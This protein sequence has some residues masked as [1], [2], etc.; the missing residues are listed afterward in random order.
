MMNPNR[1]IHEIGIGRMEEGG[2]VDS[3]GCAFEIL[4]KNP[5]KGRVE[6]KRLLKIGK[7]LKALASEISFSE[8]FGAVASVRSGSLQTW[9]TGSGRYFEEAKR[10]SR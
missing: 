9:E 8:E 1:L 6:V 7:A 5:N 3:L 10:P 2:A 4:A